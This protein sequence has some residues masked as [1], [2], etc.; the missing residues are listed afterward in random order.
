MSDIRQLLLAAFEVEHR[1]HIEA[2]RAAL[3]AA[4]EEPLPDWNDDPE[5]DAAQDRRL[6]RQDLGRLRGGAPRRTGLPAP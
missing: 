3:G 1:E 6:W 5:D 2:I 4:G